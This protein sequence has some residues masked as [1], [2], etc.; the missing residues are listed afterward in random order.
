[1]LR[2]DRAVLCAGAGGTVAGTTDRLGGDLLACGPATED[3]LGLGL[4]TAPGGAL[5]DRRGLSVSPRSGAR[6]GGA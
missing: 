5:L 3:A 4:R 6:R 1:M 2:G